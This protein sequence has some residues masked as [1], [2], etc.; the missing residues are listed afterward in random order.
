MRYKHDSMLPMGAFQQRGSVVGGRSMRLHGGGYEPTEEDMRIMDLYYAA[1]DAGLS[2]R[3]AQSSAFQQVAQETTLPTAP[4]GGGGYEVINIGT[5]DAPQTVLV[6]PSGQFVASVEN[7]GYN[8]Y[9]AIG[10]GGDAGAYTQQGFTTGQPNGSPIA[11]DMA[12]IEGRDYPVGG[13]AANNYLGGRAAMPNAGYN[14]PA[15][16]LNANIADIA[17][18]PFGAGMGPATGKPYE[19]K[20]AEGEPYKRFDAKGNLTQF[21]DRLSGKWTNAS[22]VK[23]T[24][25]SFDP[26][27]GSLVTQYQYDGKTFAPTE[28]TGG[29][30]NASFMDPYSKDTGGFLGEGGAAK[31]ATLVAAGFAPYALPY[32]AT[33]AGLGAIGAG[34]LYGAGTGGIT[35]LLSKQSPQEILKRAAIGGAL[36][37]FGGYLSGGGFGDIAEAFSVADPNALTA[38]QLDGLS[39]SGLFSDLDAANF[40]GST[41]SDVGAANLMGGQLSDLGLAAQ[42]LGYTT[43]EDAINAGFMDAQG[44]TTPLG[45]QRLTELGAHV[46]GEGSFLDK[47]KSVL[48]GGS[49]LLQGG[50]AL[51]GL[52]AASALAPK[53]SSPTTGLSAAQLQQIVSTMPSAMQGY[54]NMA[55][56]AYGYG[57]GTIDSANANLANLF[58]GFSLPTAGPYFGAGRFGD[59]YAPQAASNTPISPTGL[60]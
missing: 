30:F 58:P 20:N 24:G 47:I 35:G 49:A 21:V 33:T 9:G 15:G 38:T 40:M 51:G 41:L 59:Y 19:L 44:V 14:F 28:A 48:P 26:M 57:G 22:E 7:T 50:L 32:L 10:G 16:S 6:D 27:T 54:L 3:E 2:D 29:L 34:A 36:G 12:F 23:P 56:N 45:V 39:S 60:V 37:G 18:L 53:Q 52:A 4:T 5:P 55:G 11:R 8:Q 17:K 31:L 46:A 25:T 1:K 43:A 13:N 42:S